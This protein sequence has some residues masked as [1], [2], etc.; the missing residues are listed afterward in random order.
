VSTLVAASN[1]LALGVEEALARLVS[2]QWAATRAQALHDGSSVVRHEP[3]PD[4]GVLVSVSRE[5]PSGG[6]G[7]LERFLPKDG[8]VVQTDEWEPAVGGVRTGRWRAEL[9]GAPVSLGGTMRLEPLG[10]G[11]RW[12]VQGEVAV[13]V[14]LV[15][16]KAERLVA[17]L[18]AKLADKEAE[19]LRSAPPVA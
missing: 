16:G 18:V 9:A 15:G 10:S 6:P 13:R 12:T 14:P 8:R 17:D 7:L 11:S 1:D 2:P 5:L 19:L 4:G 3:R